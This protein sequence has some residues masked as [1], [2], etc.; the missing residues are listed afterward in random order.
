MDDYILDEVDVTPDCV[1]GGH[2]VE[3]DDIQTWKNK[4]N[5]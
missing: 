4:R 5:E 2:G 3:R 1:Q